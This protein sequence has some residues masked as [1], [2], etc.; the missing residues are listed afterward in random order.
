MRGAM[1]AARAIAA[2]VATDAAARVR[3]S[4]LALARARG[5]KVIS[6]YWAIGDELDVRPALEALRRAGRTVALPVM[7]ARG[8]PLAFRRWS[9]GAALEE[10]M[11]GIREP[12]ADAPEVVP[13]LLLVPLL[14]FDREGGRLGYGGGFYDRTLAALRADRPSTY[15]CGVCFAAQEVARV[16]RGSYDER[17]DAVMTEE[18]LLTFDSDVVA[19]P[20]GET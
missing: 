7:A 2:A 3:A 4:A 16:P 14:A 20:G 12:A 13:D 15:A 5:A 6:G 17:L 1:K 8:R 18:G 10:R 9:E 11:W 19:G